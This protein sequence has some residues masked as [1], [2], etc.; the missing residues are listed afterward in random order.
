MKRKSTIR[1]RSRRSKN[2]SGNVS[3]GAE[4]VTYLGPSRLPASIRPPFQTVQLN[5]QIAVA[6]TA[7]TSFGFNVNN[8]DPEAL[9]I[10]EFATWAG[11]YDEYRVLSIEAE[12]RPAFVNA[13][14]NVATL[15]GGTPWLTV[16][17]RNSGAVPTAYAQLIENSSVEETSINAPF[18]RIAK[19]SSTD[20]AQLIPINTAPSALFGISGF[21]IP[22]VASTTQTYGSILVRYMLQFR[23]RA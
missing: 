10:T 8:G 18:K 13:S 1:R 22:S 4:V 21:A 16:V 3:P 11:L 9:P 2:R 15:G 5:R 7:G 14:T 12:Y 6:V 17:L 23:T 20:E 19:M